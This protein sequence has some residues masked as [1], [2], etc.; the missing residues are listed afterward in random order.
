M[1]SCL[2]VDDSEVVRM[3]ARTILEGLNFQVEEAEDGVDALAACRK[4]MPDAVLLDWHMPGKN[5]IEFLR[6]LRALEN[7]QQPA[8]LFCTA[9]S[10]PQ[11]IEEALEAG[12]DEYIMKPFDNDIISS[13]FAQ[14]GLV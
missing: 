11:R 8:V 6:E 3:V 14:V 5:G 4:S 10:D 9:Q 7:V 12:A 1:T 2:V 13:K